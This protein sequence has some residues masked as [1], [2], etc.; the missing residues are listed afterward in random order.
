MDNDQSQEGI[1]TNFPI[2]VLFESTFNRFRKLDYA[3]NAKKMIKIFISNEE[4]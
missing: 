3:K 4:T 1:K 2:Y